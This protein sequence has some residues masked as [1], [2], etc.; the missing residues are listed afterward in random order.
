[1]G[2]V[3]IPDVD[4]FEGAATGRVAEAGLDLSLD[5]TDPGVAGERAARPRGRSLTPV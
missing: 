3:L 1:M 4:L 2:A 5:V